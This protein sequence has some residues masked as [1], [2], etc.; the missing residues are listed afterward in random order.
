MCYL[1]PERSSWIVGLDHLLGVLYNI[2]DSDFIL[3]VGDLNASIGD[4]QDIIP[5]IDEV[6]PRM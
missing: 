5:D 3:F 4:L 2:L 1:R 6:K